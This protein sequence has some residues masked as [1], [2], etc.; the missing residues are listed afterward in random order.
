M[1]AEPEAAHWPPPLPSVE[2]IGVTGWVDPGYFS[3]R[4]ATDVP[5]L[6]FGV[7]GND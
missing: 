6:R 2:A 3:S 7:S 1:A 4:I 5:A